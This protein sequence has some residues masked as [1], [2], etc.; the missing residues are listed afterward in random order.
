MKALRP[1]SA[2]RD[3]WR[4]SDPFALAPHQSLREVIVIFPLY[5]SALDNALP[6]RIA[7]LKPLCLG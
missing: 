2:H 4:E 1:P 6:A 5:V 7:Q 3:L